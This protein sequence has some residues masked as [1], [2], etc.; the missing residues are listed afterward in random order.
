MPRTA[1]A[2]TT[3]TAATTTTRRRS[4]KTAASKKSVSPPKPVVD[5]PVVVQEEEAEPVPD[6]ADEDTTTTSDET[7]EVEE[8]P[9]EITSMARLEIVETYI[10]DTI[11][12]LQGLLRT[13]FKE[14]RSQ[15]RKEQKSNSRRRP[16][17]PNAPKRAPFGIVQEV[18]ITDEF[19][20]FL[21][22]H[23][24]V[25]KTGKSL[26]SG[27]LCRSTR[28]TSFICDYVKKK[29]LSD[30]DNG[31]NFHPDKALSKLLDLKTPRYYKKSPKNDKDGLTGKT[32]PVDTLSY[33][34]LQTFL[35]PHFIRPE[36]P[37]Q[38]SE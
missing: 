4:K 24:L 13:D 28:G 30:K 37:V 25:D 27:A 5:E 1:T 26:E 21:D 11:K 15:L 8:V 18:E 6:M 2:T 3:S 17:D 23:N 12:V 19:R 35:A 31:K 7:R 36:R 34:R 9:Q 10:R 29:G 20:K 38:A 33:S 16:R 22:T 32:I 14:I